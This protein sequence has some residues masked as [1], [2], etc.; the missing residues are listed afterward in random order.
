VSQPG[1]QSA[2][3]DSSTNPA[4]STDS[5]QHGSTQVAHS[6][7]RLAGAGCLQSDHSSLESTVNQQTFVRLVG[8]G[9]QAG[10]CE[11]ALCDQRQSRA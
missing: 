9:Q 7:T 4:A 6:A 8:E 10:M 5:P 1:S 2:P 11:L 3:N